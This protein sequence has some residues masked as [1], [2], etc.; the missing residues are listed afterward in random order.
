MISLALVHSKG[1]TMRVLQHVAVWFS[2]LQCVAVCCSVLQCIAQQPYDESI[3]AC[4]SIISLAQIHSKEPYIHFK[5]P[6]IHFEE[7]HLHLTKPYIQK[8]WWWE[9]RIT[10]LRYTQKS[11]ICILKSPHLHL[12][13][14]Y[15]HLKEPYIQK[16]WKSH[17][18]MWV[19]LCALP[20]TEWLKHACITLQPCATHCN[21]TATQCNTF[22]HF[23]IC[24]YVYTSRIYVYIHTDIG[25]YIHTNEYNTMQCLSTLNC[26]RLRSHIL[27]CSAAHHKTL[28]HTATNGNTRNPAS[29][30]ATH[31]KIL[32]HTATYRNTHNPTCHAAPHN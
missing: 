8:T 31:H 12:K 15:I 1:P 19:C 3:A 9:A 25:I 32:Q 6:F 18:T 14:P 22:R 28:Q 27:I 30:A 11:L 23:G 7:L 20:P 29:H 4:C 21:A 16:T 5:E 26:W 24:I 10:S 13:E 17:M 2:A